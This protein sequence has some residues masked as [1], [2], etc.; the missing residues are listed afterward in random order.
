VEKSGQKGIQI[1]EKRKELKSG[2]SNALA[3]IP[4]KIKLE[5]IHIRSYHST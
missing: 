2:R 5:K 3:D 1:S 4:A